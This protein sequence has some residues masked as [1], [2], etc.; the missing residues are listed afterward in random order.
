MTHLANDL[1][2]LLPERIN[3]LA[4]MIER[5]PESYTTNWASTIDDA[6]SSYTNT[7]TINLI[8][9]WNIAL[10]E[11]GWPFPAYADLRKEI[12]GSLRD[13]DFLQHRSYLKEISSRILNGLSIGIIAFI[14]QQLHDVKREKFCNFWLCRLFSK[15]RADVFSYLYSHPSL[16]DKRQLIADIKKSYQ[17]GLW[18]A[19]I[20]T[21]FPLLDAILRNYL[22]TESLR[23]SLQTLRKAFHDAGLKLGDLMPGHHSIGDIYENTAYKNNTARSVDEDLRLIGIY[24]SSFFHFTEQYYEWHESAANEPSSVLNRHAVMHCASSF[25]TKANAIKFLTFLDL[26]LR[27]E[28]PLR[29]MIKKDTVLSHTSPP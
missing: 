5:K 12:K 17:Y 25:G 23:V 4:S 15:N 8:Q 29:I 3:M 19:C 7:S 18:S 21:T 26:T 14:G 11:C 1:K 20:S 10:I 28:K 9:T 2:K 22:E 27:L 13:F 24:L 16:K 6:F